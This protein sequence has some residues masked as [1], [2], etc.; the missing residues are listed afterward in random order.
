MEITLKQLLG[1]TSI[2]VISIGIVQW[3]LSLWVKSRL[4]KSI[5][6]E[7]DAKLEN[8]KNILKDKYDLSKTEMEFYDGMIGK[9]GG[10]LAKIKRYE[11]ENKKLLTQETALKDPSLKE[12]YME[13]IDSATEFVA[14][15]F[16]FLNEDSYCNLKNALDPTKTK[17]LA[18]LNNNF[19]D[20]M[21]KS[22]Y[23]KT[24]LNAKND[25]KE[26]N[27]DDTKTQ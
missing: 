26:L 10:F 15:S 5:Q 23:P 13:F 14:K 6:H 22:I 8:L 17:S 7:Y 1:G 24:I 20:A 12:P 18:D 2:I 9:F 21:R 27:Y 11:L 25:L 19:L 16:V 3:L 4:E